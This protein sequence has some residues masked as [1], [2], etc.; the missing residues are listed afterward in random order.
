MMLDQ[1][2]I[3]QAWQQHKSI[4][5]KRGFTLIIDPARA[6]NKERRNECMKK[7]G[8]ASKG[9]TKKRKTAKK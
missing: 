5:M 1:G 4:K 9:N 8:R 7:V 3:F 6:K 2:K